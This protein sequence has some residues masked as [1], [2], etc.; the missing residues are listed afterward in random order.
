MISP[1]P[2]DEHSFWLIVSV[3]RSKLKIDEK[4]VAL[5]LQSILGGV[6]SEFAVVEI[7]DWMFKFTVF[8]RDVGLLVYKL[9]VTSNPTFKLAF[10]LW[11]ERG[12]HLA[13]SFITEAT[14]THHPWVQVLSK[15]EKRSYADVARTYP[16]LLGSNAI[17]LGRSHHQKH[18]SAFSRL[19]SMDLLRNMSTAKSHPKVWRPIHPSSPAHNTVPAKNPGS[20][21]NTKCRAKFPGGL[22]LNLSLNL[23]S[24][25]DSSQAH[26]SLAKSP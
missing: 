12:M 6:A 8:S 1:F 7:Q 19:N 10:N 11:N 21:L 22:N 18:P 24:Q 20:A 4:N 14:C 16:P 3:A 5:I 26:P 17:P 2:D 9:G 23:G 15:K 13:N 25:F